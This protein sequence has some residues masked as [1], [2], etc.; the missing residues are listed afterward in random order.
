MA[1]AM[2]FQISRARA[3]APHKGIASPLGQLLQALECVRVAGCEQQQGGG[4][5]VGLGASL[6]PFFE[7]AFVGEEFAGEDAAGT[8][9]AGAYLLDHFRL[10][11]GEGA[12]LDFV[13]S[14][15]DFAGAM[16]LHGR[17]AVRQFVE[18]IPLG[19]HAAALISISVPVISFRRQSPPSALSFVPA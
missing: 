19:C 17:Y 4:L 7:G 5:G 13:T 2:P 8:V 14:Q 16:R 6:L 10:D 1:E 3:P 9:E 18:Q 11:L 15:R 12:R